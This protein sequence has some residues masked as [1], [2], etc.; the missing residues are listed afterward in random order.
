[1]LFSKNEKYIEKFLKNNNK[2]R[3]T[4]VEG[5]FGFIQCQYYQVDMQYA[6]KTTR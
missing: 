4:L 5:H 2:T 6:A 1:M 3:I